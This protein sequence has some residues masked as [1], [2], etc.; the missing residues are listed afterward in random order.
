M[1]KR[2]MSVGGYPVTVLTPEDGG[3]GGDVTSEQITDASAVGKKVLTAAD[4]AAARTAIGAG[5]SSLKVGTAATDAKAGNYKPTAA[6]I[7]DASDI[8]RQILKAADAAAVKALL[9]L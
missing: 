7:S 8:G 2:V 9:G 1:T 6:D 4:A 5:T 3:A